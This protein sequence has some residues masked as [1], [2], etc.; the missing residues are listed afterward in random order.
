MYQSII[1]VVLVKGICLIRLIRG[2]RGLVSMHTLSRCI[3]LYMIYYV[4]L[5]ALIY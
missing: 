2:K 1:E 5:I 4:L 3:I